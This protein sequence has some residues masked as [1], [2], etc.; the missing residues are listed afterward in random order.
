MSP[1][2]TRSFA[3]I[4]ADGRL[5]MS[6]S[7]SAARWPASIPVPSSIACEPMER[8]TYHVHAHLAIRVDGRS[9]TVPGT[10]GQT[11]TCIY[12]LHTHATDGVIHIEAPA[13]RTYTLGEF[14][15]IWGEPL[16]A[17]HV[18]DWVVPAGSKL[19]AFVDG[20]PVDGDPQLIELRDLE[21][22]ELQIGPAPL[23]PLPYDWGPGFR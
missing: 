12:W 10:I 7:R 1:K 20:Q 4:T 9:E 22:I 17:T 5:S 15:G 21:L 14:F 2:A 16:D 23:E 3:A 18:A 19:W 13:P 6:A 11:A 8:V